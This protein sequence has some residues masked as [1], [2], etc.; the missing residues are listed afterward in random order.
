MKLKLLNMI[1]SMM[2]KTNNNN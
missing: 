1:L 2:N